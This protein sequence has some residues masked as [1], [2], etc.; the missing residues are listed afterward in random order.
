M[1]LYKEVENITNLDDDVPALKS[2]LPNSIIYIVLYLMA[3]PPNLLL[4]YMGLKHGLIS[5]R[6][7]YPTLGMT[8]ANLFGLFGY[9]IQNSIYLVAVMNDIKFSLFTCSFLRTVLYNSTYVC[10]FLFPVLAIDQWLLICH[11][12][13]LRIKSLTIIISICFAIPMAVAIYDLYLQDV[14]LYDFMFYYIRM[15]PYTTVFFFF[16][17][18]PSFFI[19]SFICNLLVLSSILRRQSKSNLQQ[20]GRRL[21]PLQLQHQKGI[22]YTYILQAFMPLVLATPYYI[23]NVLFMFSIDLDMTW[24]IVGEAIIGMHPLSNAMITLTLLRPYRRALRKLYSQQKLRK[25]PYETMMIANSS[26]MPGD[27]LL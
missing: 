25:R 27:S 19:F 5:S 16:V 22:I 18:A 26:F 13:E 11:N 21:N 14:V 12:C 15:S 7:K 1:S 17:L 23:A 24:F 3:L 10:Y 4:A 8:L 6:V 2:Y 20:V 9:I